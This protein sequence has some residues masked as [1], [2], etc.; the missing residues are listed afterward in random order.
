MKQ[1]ICF[2]C[3]T[4]KQHSV[5]LLYVVFRRY[6]C[7]RRF[8]SFVLWVKFSRCSVNFMTYFIRQICCCSLISLLQEVYL[9]GENMELLQ[10]AL[11]ALIYAPL[12]FQGNN[13]EKKRK[14]AKS[15][16]CDWHDLNDCCCYGSK[17]REVGFDR[18]GRRLLW[19]SIKWQF[20]FV[21]IVVKLHW[22]G[23]VG[24][25]TLAGTSH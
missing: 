5:F 22:S 19:L 13:I 11:I 14:K 1:L 3:H 2:D 6:C 23:I 20:L 12:S 21:V 7:C 15:K 24:D 17:P 16:S 18:D 9:T 4:S 8:F 10:K 25:G